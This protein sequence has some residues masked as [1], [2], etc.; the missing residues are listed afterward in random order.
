MMEL[1]QV[2]EPEAKETSPLASTDDNSI[3]KEGTPTN[4]GEKSNL[5]NDGEIDAE[6]GKTVERGL[7]GSQL[8]FVLTCVS[9]AGIRFGLWCYESVT[10][11]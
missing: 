3:K 4:R 2:F 9:Y 11:I 1:T 10:N 7:W 8:E 5:K 6:G